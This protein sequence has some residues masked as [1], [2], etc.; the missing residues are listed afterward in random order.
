V[1]WE[2]TANVVSTSI[3]SLHVTSGV[4][5]MGVLSSRSAIRF[6]VHHALMRARG[7]VCQTLNNEGGKGGNEG[8]REG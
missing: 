2:R 4:I 1:K 3:A 7:V 6:F 5:V 8:D